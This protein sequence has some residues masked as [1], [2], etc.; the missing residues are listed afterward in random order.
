MGSYVAGCLKCL[1]TTVVE[2]LTGLCVDCSKAREQKKERMKHF[3]HAREIDPKAKD[4]EDFINHLD[5]LS[6]DEMIDMM[7][8]QILYT[9]TYGSIAEPKERKI[10]LA[11]DMTTYFLIY[12]CYI[13]I[14]PVIYKTIDPRHGAKKML[15]RLYDNWY[16]Q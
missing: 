3:S 4:R 11:W 15:I 5:D 2:D 7:P 8:T 16:M 13:D 10:D 9:M 12:Y 6:V 1:R 14:K